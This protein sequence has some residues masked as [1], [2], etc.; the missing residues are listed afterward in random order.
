[1]DCAYGANGTF[2]FADCGIIP[3]PSPSQLANIAASA[4]ELFRL[5]VEEEPLVALLSFSTKG[6][7]SHEMV[8]KIVRARE[9]IEK[10]YPELTVD[11]ELQLDAAIVPEVARIKAPESKVAGAANVL[12]FPDLN[13]G[14]IA[15]KLVQ[16]L[17]K[18]E[19]IGPMMNGLKKPCSDLSRGCTVDEVVNAVCTTAIRVTK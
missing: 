4:S 7:A 18:A 10:K 12:I 16:R 11:G 3:D 1:P 9:I 6:S 13:A 5:L 17:A 2:V 19:V 14:N 15:Y 8:D